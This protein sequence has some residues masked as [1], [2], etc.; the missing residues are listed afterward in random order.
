MMSEDV[1][2]RVGGGRTAV[3]LVGGE[4]TRQR[5]FVRRSLSHLDS[6]DQVLGDESGQWASAQIDDRTTYVRM[7]I[8]AAEK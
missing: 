1:R 5:L 7:D 2:W 8:S 6:E 3:G 4:A